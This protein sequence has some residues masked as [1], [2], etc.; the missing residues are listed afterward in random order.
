M[1]RIIAPVLPYLA[2]EV[3]HYLLYDGSK[4]ALDETPSLFMKKWTP[5]VSFCFPTKA[6]LF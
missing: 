4:K 3:H 6:T 2:E 5:M 1:S